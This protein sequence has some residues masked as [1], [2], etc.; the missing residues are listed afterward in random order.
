LLAVVLINI[1][2]VSLPLLT[3]EER[4]PLRIILVEV[5]FFIIFMALHIRGHLMVARYGSFIV[6]LALQSTACVIHGRQNGFD[7]LFYA[8]AVLPTLFF[9]KPRHYLSLFA[10]SVVALIAVHYTYKVTQPLLIIPGDFIFYWNLF[11]TAS[12]ILLV[13][14][15]FKSGY[16]R[17]QLKLQSQHD[18]MAHQKEEIEVINNNLEQIV[19]DRTEKIKDQESRISHF[20]FI[21]AHKVRSPLARIIGLLNLIDLDNN[22]DHAITECLPKLRASAEE[23]N[24][25]LREVTHTLN[26]IRKEGRENT[27]SKTAEHAE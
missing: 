18:V 5:I 24:D 23:L 22:K 13:M 3:L 14:Y 6:V 9:D 20:A 27:K 25:M 19:I 26:G 11:S 4:W 12:I 17:S 8:I 21:N 2:I 15:I 1:A 10:V 7:Y 16:E